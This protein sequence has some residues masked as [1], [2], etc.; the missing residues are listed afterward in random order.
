MKTTTPAGTSAP[1]PTAPAADKGVG[2]AVQLVSSGPNTINVIKAVREVTGLGLKEAK[3]FVDGVP[4]VVKESLSSDEAAAI[5]VKLEAAGA[6][7]EVISSDGHAVSIESETT[8]AARQEIPAAV[9][10][11]A[12]VPGTTEA[13]VS[14]IPP[15]VPETRGAISAS[16]LLG[17][18]SVRGTLGTVSKGLLVGSVGIP[19]DRPLLK[20]PNASQLPPFQRGHPTGSAWNGSRRRANGLIVLGLVLMLL[21]VAGP[22]RNPSGMSSYIAVV[23]LLLLLPASL[24]I[25]SGTRA[26][27]QVSG[28][29]L[30]VPPAQEQTRRAIGKPGLSGLSS[31][32]LIGEYLRYLAREWWSGQPESKAAATC[33]ACSGRP[34]R[35]NE[36]YLIGSSLWCKECYTDKEVEGQ[37]RRNPDSAGH[38]VLQRAQRWAERAMCDICGGSDEVKGDFVGYQLDYQSTT[39]FHGAYRTTTTFTRVHD[40]TP[41]TYSACLKCARAALLTELRQLQLLCA[42]LLWTAGIGLLLGGVVTYASQVNTVGRLVG[43]IFIAIGMLAGC[44]WFSFG[45]GELLECKELALGFPSDRAKVAKAILKLFE[46]RVLA[47]AQSLK[48]TKY[49]L[50]SAWK[51]R[52]F[53][54]VS[55]EEWT[56]KIAPKR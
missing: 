6:R 41:F 38:G 17:G 36:G 49:S 16:S 1:G 33:D 32:R 20:N 37:L 30:K 53:F 23:G 11:G 56:T 15:P 31:E 27:K 48:P 55:L 26:R 8:A 9:A 22:F 50:G 35:R 19:P 46:K 29:T 44:L 28:D 45:F 14:S 51:G 4:K 2:P 13:A 5:K 43:G 10:S 42:V 7:A 54:V 3:E 39:Q 52:N 12:W 34:V 25:W 18:V 24:L 21:F 47:Y 40:V